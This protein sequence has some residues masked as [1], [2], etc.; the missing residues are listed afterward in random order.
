MQAGSLLKNMIYNVTH[1]T[2][3]RYSSP[4]SVCHNILILESRPS[5]TSVCQQFELRIHPQPKALVRRVDMF[6]NIVQRFS[7]D[8]NH[9]QLSIS[10]NSLIVLHPAT[11][12]Q[13]TSTATCSQVSR[14]CKTQT[15]ANWLAVS[16]FSFDSPRIKRSPEFADYAASQLLDDKPV[17]EAAIEL[18]HQI[19]TDFKYDKDATRVDTPTES[20]FRERHGVCQDFAHI[21][22]ACLRSSGLPAR[23]VSGYLRTN[24]PPGKPRLVGN[25]QSHAWFSIYCGSDTGWVDLDPTNDCV[26]GADH[27]PVAFGRDYTDV[28]PVKGIFLGGGE[29]SMSVSVD[30]S[31]VPPSTILEPTLS[32]R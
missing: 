27:V 10:A 20:S 22:V 23:Y 11:V 29:T 8:V 17:L 16:P 30:V 5:A 1:S 12:T 31:E 25:D 4:V 21:A 14:S 13:A 19:Y 2:V 32:E 18:T 28:V 7:L 9:S 26:C 6:G 24:P 15:D 3:Y